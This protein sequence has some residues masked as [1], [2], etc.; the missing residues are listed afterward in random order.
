MII[1]RR[2]ELE[3][4]QEIPYEVTLSAASALRLP[5]RPSSE[6]AAERQIINDFNYEYDFPIPSLFHRTSSC[7]LVLP[8]CLPFWCIDK[9]TNFSSD[10]HRLPSLVS[11]RK[12]LRPTMGEKIDRPIF[13]LGDPLHLHSIEMSLLLS[14]APRG[15]Q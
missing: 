1:D 4:V 10:H 3:D 2:I 7:S 11:S 15:A 13:L 6:A 12:S 14:A 9:L 8:A 5:V